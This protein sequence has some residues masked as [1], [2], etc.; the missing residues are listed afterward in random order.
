MSNTQTA[1]KKEQ[2]SFSPSENKKAIENHKKTATHLEA[3]AKNHLDAA[4]H[5]EDEN[6]NKAAKS[7]ITAQGHMALA[8]D[9][10][11]DVLKQHALNS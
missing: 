1:T 8:N 6:Q 9:A 10:H 2:S 7:T 4:K 5:Y 3:A 11:K